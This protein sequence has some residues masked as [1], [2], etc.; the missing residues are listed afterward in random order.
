[1]RWKFEPV[2]EAGGR[3]EGRFAAEILQAF[4][5]PA[6]SAGTAMKDSIG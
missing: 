1:M 3:E 6:F 4:E 5:L 2:H